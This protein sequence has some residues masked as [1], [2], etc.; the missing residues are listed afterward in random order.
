L[1][2]LWNRIQTTEPVTEEEVSRM[3]QILS[4]YQCR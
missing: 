4:E 3:N 1:C 2:E